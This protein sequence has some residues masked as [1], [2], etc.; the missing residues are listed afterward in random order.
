M[1]RFRARAR[2]LDM[3]GRQQIAGIPTALHE[4]FKNA[5]DAYAHNVEVDFFRTRELLLLRDDGVGMSREDFES[6]W[7]TLATESKVPVLEN[8]MPS[9][10]TGMKKRP[11]MGEKGIGRLA[12]ATIGPIVLI[13]TRADEE[14][15]ITACLIHWGLFEIVGVDLEDIELPIET[16]DGLSRLDQALVARLRDSLI[17]TCNQIANKSKDPKCSKIRAELKQW[18]PPLKELANLGFGPNL[19][20]S[21]GVHFLIHPVREELIA[22]IDIAESNGAS[23]LERMLLGFSNSFSQSTDDPLNARFRDHLEDGQTVDRIADR[24]FFTQ[25]EYAIADHKVAGE[26]D[27]QGNFSGTISVYGEEPQEISIPLFNESQSRA[28]GPFKLN[29]AYVQ[30]S[31]SDTTIP[32]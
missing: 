7:L 1:A 25:S 12:I 23:N 29:F 2:T 24:E 9:P 21:S 30:G 27:K 4:L 10:R 8:L 15:Q 19:E 17:G 22:D 13:F 20:S 31:P 28:C 11:V 18:D 32:L 16:L 14:Q 3:L 26:F 5:Y 6:R